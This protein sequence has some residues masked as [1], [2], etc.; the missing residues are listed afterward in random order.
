[1][2]HRIVFP[3]YMERCCG[4]TI[5]EQGVFFAFYFEFNLAR[6]DIRQNMA[7]EV[8]DEWSFDEEQQ[9]IS[10]AGRTRPFIGLWG[11]RPLV[12]REGLGQ[13]TVADS[14]VQLATPAG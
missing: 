8:E 11:G 6:F 12:S 9:M 13:L 7:T 4:F 3:G 1:M 10:F 5:P 2:E 14:R